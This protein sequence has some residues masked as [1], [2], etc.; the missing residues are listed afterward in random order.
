[1]IEKCKEYRWDNDDVVSDSLIR[2]I[3]NHIEELKGDSN[4]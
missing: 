2:I 1:M 4:G 3:D